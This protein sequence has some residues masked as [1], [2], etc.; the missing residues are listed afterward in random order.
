MAVTFDGKK[1]LLVDDDQDMLTALQA[2]LADTGADISTAPDGNAAIRVA[3]A[4]GR[5]PC[6]LDSLLPTRSGSPVP[7]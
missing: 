4:C 7:S 1:I 6:P 3:A 2:V 5:D